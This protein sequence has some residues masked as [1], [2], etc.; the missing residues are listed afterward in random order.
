MI[1]SLWYNPP[2]HKP[3][4]L[5]PPPPP[6]PPPLIVNCLA[7]ADGLLQL[8]WP[9]GAGRMRDLQ[10]KVCV[11][12]KTQVQSHPQHVH[13]HAQRF[14]PPVF[15]HPS[16]C[17]PRCLTELF[18]AG[19]D[20]RLR[21]PL[22]KTTTKNNNKMKN[23]KLSHCRETSLTQREGILRGGDKSFETES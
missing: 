7:F 2:S 17:S 19:P 21:K 13:T 14:N 5:P 23:I 3:P 16:L 9:E 22:C 1:L 6:P 15:T 18:I 4:H 8:M 20:R 10:H 11:N 12:A